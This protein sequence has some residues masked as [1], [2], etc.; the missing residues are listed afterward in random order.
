MC[1]IVAVLDVGGSGPVSREVLDRMAQAVA[2]RGPDER[3]LWIEGPVG[4]AAQRLRVVDLETGQQPLVSEDGSIRLVA[5]GEVYN[6]SEL[7][8]ALLARGHRFAS[9]T[10]TEVILHA[11]EDDGPASLERLEGMFAF[12]LWDGRRR[13]LLL[14]RDRFG[15][16]PLYYAQLPRTFLLASE[17]KALLVHPDVPRDLDWHAL[18]QYLAHEYVPAPQAIFR[19]IRKLEPA[20]YMTVGADGTHAIDRYWSPPRPS[21]QAPSAPEAADEVVARLRRSV[22]SRI[23]CDVSWG[24]LLSG[25]IDS[26]LVTALATEISSKPVKTF[27]IGFEEPTY[28]ERHH[29]A[30]VARAFGAEH[31]ETLVR[32]ADARRLLSEVACILDEP[33]A[34]ASSLPALLLSRLAREHV[35]VALS[36]DGGD[37]LFCGYPTQTAHRAA[38]AYRRLPATVRRAIV[39]AA[40]RLP[41]SHRYLSFDFAARRFLRDAARPSVE[42]HLRWMGSFPPEAQT[43]LL[44]PEVQREVLRADPYTAARE[45]VT[46]WR[47]ETVSDVATALDVLF[48]LADDNLVQTDRA[49]MSVALEVRAP[50]LDLGVAEYALRLPAALR[51]GLW[52]TKPLLRRAARTLLPGRVSRRRKHGFGV[53]TGTWLRGPLRELAVELLEPG[54]I[55]RQ[56]LFDAAYVSALLDRHLRGVAY[57]R[58]ELWTLLMFELWAGNYYGT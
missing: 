55:R 22:A 8:A 34:D 17:L 33:F 27:A 19:A 26:S 45:A 2:H 24:C 18:T 58:K 5:N 4:L 57:H 52:R 13:R 32:G 15:E 6:A 40:E 41:T 48:Y 46:A 30:A 56:G 14:A 43:R 44:A 10:D 53:P 54:R 42:R 38:E 16:K 51:R 49:S 28:D 20:H 35:T 39:F 7:R 9:R 23:L 1:G 25:G 36:G 12:A 47:P 21:R 11:Y 29:A 37:E 31:H 3:G 50:F